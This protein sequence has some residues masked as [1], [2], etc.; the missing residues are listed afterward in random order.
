M[1]RN[2]ALRVMVFLLGCLF[3]LIGVIGAFVPLL[4]TTVFIILAAWCFIK[5]S[6]KTHQRLRENRIVGPSLIRW[7]ERGAISTQA[8]CLAISMIAC[9]LGIV[10]ITVEILWVKVLV[11][12]MLFCCSIYI[13]TRPKS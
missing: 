2:K 8:K 6:P 1:I 7:E 5:S 10:W 9:S 11:T 13:A 3:L 4:P 12:V